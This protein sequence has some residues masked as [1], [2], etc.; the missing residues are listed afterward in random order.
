MTSE[1][2]D[3]V[4]EIDAEIL[5][6]SGFLTLAFDPMKKTIDT[7]TSLGMRNQVKVMIG[8]GPVDEHA[9][10]YTGADACG[11][12]AKVCKNCKFFEKIIGVWIYNSS[13]WRW[14]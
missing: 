14:A 11:K 10:I 1:F 2:V 4:K 3:K 5:G 8:G 12:D 7:L 9:R 6:L 13:R